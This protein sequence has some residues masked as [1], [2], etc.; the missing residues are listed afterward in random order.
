MVAIRRLEG[1][2][3]ASFSDV[4][5]GD[6]SLYIKYSKILTERLGVEIREVLSQ[7][8]VDLIIVIFGVDNV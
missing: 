1:Y 6:F 2:R 4:F 3:G 7:D 5:W 8:L